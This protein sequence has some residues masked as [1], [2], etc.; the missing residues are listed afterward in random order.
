MVGPD[1][2]PAHLVMGW[3]VELM[4]SQIENWTSPQ[5]FPEGRF[6]LDGADPER[7]YRVF[8]LQPKRKL[9]AL[10]ELKFDPKGPVTVRLE[11][12]AT[13]R[14]TMVDE[15][16]R[17]LEHTQIIPWI[18]LTL[19]D[20]A[21]KTEDFNDDS[22]AAAYAMFTTTPLLPT[23]PAEFNY[24]NLIPGVRFYI[25][26]AG[27]HHPIPALKPGEVRDLGKINARQQKEGN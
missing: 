23:Y 21:L 13:A 26:A 24:D 11:P 12:A 17:P 6:R 16:G 9:G 1:G 19:E 5:P 18:V 25:A 3:C 10:A 15:K 8:F 4:A 27:T 14:G 22:M 20:R 7:T 2:T